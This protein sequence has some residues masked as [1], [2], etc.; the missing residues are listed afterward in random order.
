MKVPKSGIFAYCNSVNCSDN[1]DKD[2]C[3][4]GCSHALWMDTL[5]VNGK[6]WLFEY[7]PRFGPVFLRKDGEH[8]VH[9]PGEKHPVW[10]EFEKWENGEPK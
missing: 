7:N 2:Y 5:I 1:L 9:Q 4:N 3:T 6:K 10:K 8:K